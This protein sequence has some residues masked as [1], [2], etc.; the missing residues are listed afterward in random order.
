M[1]KDF[2]KTAAEIRKKFHGCYLKIIDK[3][4]P[5]EV[6][7][8]NPEML[9]FLEKEYFSKGKTVSFV[10]NHTNSHDIP[11][12]A[13]ALKKHFYVVIAKEGLKLVQKI[14]FF[15]NGPIFIS[16]SK[17]ESRRKVQDKIILVQKN[18]YCTLTFSEASWNDK[19][20]KLM[21]KLFNGAVNASK[22]TKLDIIPLILEYIDGKCYAKIG[23]PFIVDEKKDSREQSDDL[24]DAMVTIRI[25]LLEEKTDF[26]PEYTILKKIEY[27]ANHW[28][29]LPSSKMDQ[30]LKLYEELKNLK[31]NLEKE[32]NRTIEK[33]WDECPGLDKKFENSCIYKD[34]DSPEEAFEHLNILINNPKAAFLFKPNIKGY[35]K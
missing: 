2:N 8:V 17:K 11:L 26:Y 16:R 32:F 20:E 23:N 29:E 12:A 30:L 10:A 1:N 31:V 22:K 7:V 18:G 5:M 27:I 24:R 13:K 35:K 15:I 33:Y 3:V 34:E 21:N 28:D 6:E 4:D 19:P 14:G 25:S 9:D